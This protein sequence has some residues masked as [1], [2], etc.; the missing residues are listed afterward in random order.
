M[1]LL[2]TVKAQ[3][4]ESQNA[5]QYITG[6]LLLLSQSGSHFP[7]VTSPSAKSVF[8]TVEAG[9]DIQ[10]INSDHF[11][12]LNFTPDLSASSACVCQSVH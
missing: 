10:D 12:A 5:M 4:T 11:W 2:I 7:V 8:L 3:C 1:G 9:G 6:P